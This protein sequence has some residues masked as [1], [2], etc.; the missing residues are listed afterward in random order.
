MAVFQQLNAE[1][2]T[3]VM[4]THEEDIARYAGRVIHMKDGRVV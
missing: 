3:L 4:V 2:M 1:G